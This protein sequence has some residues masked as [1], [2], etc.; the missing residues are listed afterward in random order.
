MEKMT[1]AYLR[2]KV[3]QLCCVSDTGL[4]D[5]CR[6]FNQSYSKRPLVDSSNSTGLYTCLKRLKKLSKF[7]AI[8]LVFAELNDVTKFR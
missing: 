8:V 6:V 1:V 5:F 3:A 7:T 2:D 4:K